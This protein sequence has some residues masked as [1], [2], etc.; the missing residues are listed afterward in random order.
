MPAAGCSGAS[1]EGNGGGGV[2]GEGGESGQGG[3]GATG[4]EGGS[5]G[6]AP[7]GIWTGTG[8][9]GDGTFSICFNV[10]EGGSALVRPLD[11][12][13]ECMGSSLSVQFDA[14]EGGFS[15]DE[16]IPIVDG[17]F[18]LLNQEGGLA[19]YWDIS[20]TLD[21]DSASGSAEVG[22]V[23]EGTCAGSWTASPVP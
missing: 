14:C 20:G 17:S 9:G 10:N 6:T 7:L 22:A 21:G 16:E 2:G 23:L 15:T 3:V 11:A 5:G 8:D 13:N 12:S 1:T 4:G 19:G 18:S